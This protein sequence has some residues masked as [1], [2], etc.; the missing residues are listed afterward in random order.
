MDSLLSDTCY[1][2]KVK[3]TSR[4]F[5]FG[6]NYVSNDSTNYFHNTFEAL[7][8]HS[9]NFRPLEVMHK[10]VIHKHAGHYLH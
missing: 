2:L 1:L 5:F 9:L 3:K 4:T 6:N 8:I 7:V 10:H